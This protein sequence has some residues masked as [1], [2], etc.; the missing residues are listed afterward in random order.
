MKKITLLAFVL[1]STLAF[2]QKVKYSFE[3][4][5]IMDN[6]YFEQPYSG[7]STKKPALVILKIGEQVEG[8]VTNVD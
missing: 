8:T 7:F 4:R 2:S 1:V 5:R 3:E 6:D